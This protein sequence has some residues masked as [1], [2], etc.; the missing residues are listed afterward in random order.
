MYLPVAPK[1]VQRG[2]KHR[3]SCSCRESKRS[4]PSHSC[5]TDSSALAHLIGCKRGKWISSTLVKLSVVQFVIMLLRWVP[6][7]TGRRR[8]ELSDVTT[9]VIMTSECWERRGN[10]IWLSL[11]NLITKSLFPS[12]QIARKWRPPLNK[13]HIQVKLATSHSFI[14]FSQS[15]AC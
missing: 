14:L 12:L 4:C 11:I 2:C 10:W 15:C 8:D 3:N 7:E 6:L 1:P 5:N 13:L 9:D